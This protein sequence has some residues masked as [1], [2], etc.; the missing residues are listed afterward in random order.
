M[1]SRIFTP[2]DMLTCIRHIMYYIYKLMLSKIFP[3]YDMLA[4]IRHIT[5]YRL[6][7]NV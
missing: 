2:Y 4:R 3:H 7:N 1:L 5:M 6:K